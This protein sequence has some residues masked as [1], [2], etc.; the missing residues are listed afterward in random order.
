MRTEMHS[1]DTHAHVKAL[2]T[3]GL[4]E[5]EAEAIIKTLVNSRE[6]DFSKLATKEQVAVLERAIAMTQQ[7][8]EKLAT[9]EQLAHL[10][11]KFINKIDAVEE[12]L[13]SKIDAIKHELKAEIAN[14]QTSAVRW[15]L[16]F[17]IAIIGMIATIMFRMFNH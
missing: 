1:F 5:P 14:S 13:T 2:I 3:A 8:M 12:K 7:D 17:F 6:Y 9:K 4:K 10:E 16:P 11:E 15:M